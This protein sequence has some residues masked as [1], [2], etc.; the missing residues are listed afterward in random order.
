MAKHTVN[1]IKIM[2]GPSHVTLHVFLQ[3]D[4]QSGDLS[5]YVILDPATDLQ[6]FMPQHQDLLVKQ[7]W[8]ELG[9]FSITFAFNSLTPQ[10]FWTLTPGASLH[11]DWRFFGGLR[12]Y[13]STQMLQNK[14]QPN[15]SPS[16]LPV[17]TLPLYGT[18][19]I[20]SD[21]KLMIS[22]NGFFDASDSGTFV[23]WMEKRDRVTPQPY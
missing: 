14:G 13:S 2:D 1:R 4:G 3:C 10:P 16:T 22:T 18:S 6:P 5:N 9:G 11:H 23:L 15:A 7:V 19:G 8:Y 21:G 20:D 17:E 12:D